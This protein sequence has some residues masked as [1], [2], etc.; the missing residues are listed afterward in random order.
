MAQQALGPG[1]TVPRRRVLFGLLDAAGWTWAG[2]K[3]GFWLIVIIFMLGYLPD[4][5]YY[6]TVNRTIDLGILA[7][8]PI[9]LCPPVPNENLPC[10][11]PVGALTP[12]HPSPTE[13]VN[14]SLPEP[15]TDG[16]AVQVGENIL[17]VGGS[18][19]ET[20]QSTVFVAQ[21]IPVGNVGAWE[22]GP[23]LPEPRTNATVLVE[24][25]N[26]YVF[27]GLD[28]DGNP[29]D[30]VYVLKPNPETGA[31]GEWEAAEETLT[32]P[33]PRA[34]AGIAATATGLV[35]AGGTGPDGVSGTA[36]QAPFNA[37]GTLED[38]QEV[39]QLSAA[40]TDATI[41]STGTY[42]W[43]YGGAGADGN[44]VATIQRGEFGLPPG[45]GEP[46]NPDEGLVV[47][48]STEDGSEPAR[49][50][51]ERLGLGRKRD[52]VSR[53]W[54][55]RDDLAARGVLGSPRQRGQHPRVEAPRRQRP[56]RPWHRGCRAAAHRTEHH[57]DRGSIDRRRG[58]AGPGLE[59]P[60][61][62][63]PTGP[64]LPARHRRRHGP[65]PEDRG[66]DRAAARLHERGAGRD[67]ELHH[68]ADH[69][70]GIRP[71]GAEPRVHQ[72]VRRA[73]PPR[74]G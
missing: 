39:A 23:A 38:W 29:T 18:D 50:A 52:P 17:Y 28:A 31:L 42:V 58:V 56:A 36:W 15:R 26:V 22:E 69:R 11:L 71:P 37:Q 60:L 10:P 4:R 5:A 6:F 70:L 32:L 27:G 46:E 73:A 47:A 35:L 51:D 20:A 74:D 30:T 44:P 57:P 65:G 8:S 45:P 21:A 3:A 67:G 13:P 2:L 63:R 24:G 72:P 43:L 1:A 66:R 54:Q 14:L 49:A 48:W 62:P 25:G 33:E 41:V 7:W 12:W 68:P 59:C 64:V 16:G 53:R 61:Q 19:G 9:N 40:V 55:R 34:G